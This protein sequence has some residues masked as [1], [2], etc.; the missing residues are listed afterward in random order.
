MIYIYLLR[1][2]VRRTRTETSHKLASKL[3]QRSNETPLDFQEKI[4]IDKWEVSYL[5]LLPLQ[6]SNLAVPK[7]TVETGAKLL[8]VLVLYMQFIGLFVFYLLCSLLY[9]GQFLKILLYLEM[10]KVNMKKNDLVSSI[11]N[12]TLDKQ[13]NKKILHLN[14]LLCK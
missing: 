11:K 12:Q 13:K 14:K 2:A 10:W 9:G 4:S 7:S 1:N 3:I 5:D 8:L 6:W